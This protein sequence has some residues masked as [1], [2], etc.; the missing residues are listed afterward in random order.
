MKI[1]FFGTYDR[2]YSRNKILLTGLER[3][4]VSVVEVHTQLEQTK[5]N[6]EKHV[7]IVAVIHRLL[8]KASFL[9]V[10][11]SHLSD[12]RRSD[13]IFCAYPGHLDLPLAWFI[14]KIF[15][16]PVV[17]DPF[18][19]ITDVF[20][21]DFAIVSEKSFK[22]RFFYLAESLIFS[23]ADRI[24]AD[25]PFQQENYASLLHIPNERMRVVLLGA[26]DTVYRRVEAQKKP[27]NRKFRVVY[28]G[29]YN[30]IHGVEYMIEAA[31]QLRDDP[32]IEFLF[33]GDGQ[34]YPL[35][36]SLVEKYHLSNVH[37]HTLTEKDALPLLQTAD[38]FLGLFGKHKSVWRAI[39][40]KVL[41]GLAMGKAVITGTGAAAES[42]FVHKKHLMLL[43]PEDSAAIAA[44]I[45]ELKEHP[46]LRETVTREGYALYK[47]LFTPDAIGK[48]L[49]KIFQELSHENP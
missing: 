37:F 48:E 32:Q 4:G 22:Y 15:R 24:L 6:S 40:N 41:Q 30:P 42:V 44:A 39:P 46:K 18:F 25:T 8:R 27:V 38:V 43:P 29:L 23:L 2:N 5:L 34:T 10:V 16:K 28:Y 13:I 35:A 9:P 26:D 12:I 7:G 45:R 20:A 47:R 14:G 33:I 11:L 19:S 49:L 3:L 21:H 31:R 17:F 36:V 1:C